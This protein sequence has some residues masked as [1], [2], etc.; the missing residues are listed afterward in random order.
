META[1][2]KI[3]LVIYRICLLIAPIPPFSFS[4][5]KCSVADPGNG[6]LP[7]DPCQFWSLIQ[8]YMLAQ[9][10]GAASTSCHE[11]FQE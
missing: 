9:E 6:F 5:Q 7:T 3:L 1:R 2:S 10:Q 11:N 4:A 8:T